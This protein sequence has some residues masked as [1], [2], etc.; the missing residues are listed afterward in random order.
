MKKDKEHMILAMATA[1]D[2]VKKKNSPFGAVIVKNDVLVAAAHS[3]VIQKND[4]T[5]HAEVTVI[6]KA[7]K[8]LK[9]WDLSGCVI[10]STTEPCPMCFSAIHWARIDK[11]VYGADIETAKKFGFNE[12]EIS[13]YKMRSMGKTKIEIQADFMSKEN[14]KLFE[15]WKEFGGE[16]Y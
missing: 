9:T 7:C 16:A 2:G 15:F 10:Y 1:R 5:A 13:N 14:I 6:R 8:A 11:I 3:E 12:L 4:S